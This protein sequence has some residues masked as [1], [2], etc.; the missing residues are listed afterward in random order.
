MQK[1]V[2]HSHGI[3]DESTPSFRIAGDFTDLASHPAKLLILAGA[4][5][6][7]AVSFTTSYYY[8]PQTVPVPDQVVLGEAATQNT[9]IEN[10]LDIYQQ[11]TAS[12]ISGYITAR[13]QSID[14]LN[15]EDALFA[16]RSNVQS[17]YDLILGMSVPMRYRDLHI[18]LATLLSDERALV[19]SADDLTAGDARINELSD[20]WNAVFTR[21]PW[22]SEN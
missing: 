13:S 3:I 8:F 21:Y 7:S 10:Q 5:V 1:K 15:N 6:L 11:S 14:A 18:E 16:W 22:I 12:I 4:F 9:D 17:A 19:L 2:K 20:Q